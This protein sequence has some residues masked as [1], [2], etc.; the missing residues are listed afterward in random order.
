MHTKHKAVFSPLSIFYACMFQAKINGS[1]DLQKCLSASLFNIYLYPGISLTDPTYRKENW[2]RKQK[3][4]ILLLFV[5]FWRTCRP[6][7]NE[8]FVLQNF[9]SVSENYLKMNL[10]S[11][12]QI[13]QCRLNKRM[14]SPTNCKGLELTQKFVW[15]GKEF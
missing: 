12:P 5:I 4:L 3:I 14:P 11:E 2:R 8:K 10:F 15:M 1:P 6:E 7:S 9:L 13:H